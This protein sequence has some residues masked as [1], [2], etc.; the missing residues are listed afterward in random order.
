MRGTNRANNGIC[1]HT[2]HHRA[3]VL[4][5]LVRD[6]LADTF[7]E[8]S[9]IDFVNHTCDRCVEV[10]CKA[11]R[12]DPAKTRERMGKQIDVL[13]TK[14]ARVKDLYVDGD[15]SKEEYRER[16]ALLGEDV[17]RVTDER[18]RLDDIDGEMERIE[19]LRAALLSVEK[20]F[21]GH[22]CFTGYRVGLD[23]DMMERTA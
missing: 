9:S 2:K 8:E 1:P 19:H 10:L 6:T 16:R 7:R 15:V 4:E 22:N 14:L 20:P 3:E 23:N 17:A 12:S 5:L 11:H 18:S 13:G 21:S